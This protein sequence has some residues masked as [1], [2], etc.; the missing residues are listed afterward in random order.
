MD[1][2]TI[3]I[4]LTMLILVVVNT[5]MIFATIG[6]FMWKTAKGVGKEL[7]AA[8]DLAHNVASDAMMHLKAQSITQVVDAKTRQ[9]VGQ[10]SVQEAAFIAERN[11]KQIEEQDAER[12]RRAPETIRDVAGN[13]IKLADYETVDY[14]PQAVQQ[15]AAQDEERVRRLLADAKSQKENSK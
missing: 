9:D 8:L 10:I 2:L 5:V 3:S 6:Y 13:E 4:Q 15:L 12:A 14:S 11:K 1:A 7:Q